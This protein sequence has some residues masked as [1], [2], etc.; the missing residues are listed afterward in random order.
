MEI[1]KGSFVITS[2]SRFGYI[3]DIEEDPNGTDDKLC[4]VRIGKN[5]AKIYR[6]QLTL[7]NDCINLKVKYNMNYVGKVFTDTTEIFIPKTTVL[8]DDKTKFEDIIKL[9]LSKKFGNGVELV[10]VCIS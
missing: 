4:T 6:S 1:K 5:Y 10:S 2:K 3:I 9:A 8:F 7:A